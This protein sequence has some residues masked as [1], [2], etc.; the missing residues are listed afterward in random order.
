ML[1]SSWPSVPAF[2][3]VR[4]VF[5]M[6]E[7]WV[8]YLR[9]R[10]RPGVSGHMLRMQVSGVQR[11]CRRGHCWQ[12]WALLAGV[13]YHLVPGVGTAGRGSTAGPTAGRGTAGVGTA[14][15]GTAGRGDIAPC[16][17]C[18]A[19]A[20]FVLLAGVMYHLVLPAGLLLLSYCWLAGLLFS[21]GKAHRAP[22][23]FLLV[24]WFRSAG[25]LCP[26]PAFACQW[27]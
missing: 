18:R 22:S 17:S 25:L 27:P 14:G 11:W 6:R 16:A 9:T 19:F 13:I 3:A 15:R 21:A 10:N 1:A 5:E 4:S 23:S 20:A 26:A 8:S 24:S 12:G 7:L 2:Q